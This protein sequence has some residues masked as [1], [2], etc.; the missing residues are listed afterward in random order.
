MV[1]LMDSGAKQDVV[2]LLFEVDQNRIVTTQPSTG[3]K[4][5]S[6]FSIDDDGVL[7]VKYA[8]IESLFRKVAGP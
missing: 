8:G 3:A 7:R 2:R 6:E 1:Y 4:E 5:T